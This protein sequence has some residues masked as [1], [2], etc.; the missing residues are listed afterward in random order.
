MVKAL[1]TIVHTSPPCYQAQY[2]QDQKDEE[3]DLSYSG[4]AGSNTAKTK[5][6][7]YYS[8]H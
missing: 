2:E 4:C 1:Y 3:Q 6:C 8:Y 7:R 5:Y